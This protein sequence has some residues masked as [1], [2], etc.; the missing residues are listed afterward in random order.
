MATL[1]VI[2]CVQCGKQSEAT[3][4]WIVGWGCLFNCLAVCSPECADTYATQHSK[5]GCLP[6]G[7]VEFCCECPEC[8]MQLFSEDGQ[9]PEHEHWED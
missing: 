7:E 6:P 1:S 5:F 2:E 8:G 4:S 9:V 3:S